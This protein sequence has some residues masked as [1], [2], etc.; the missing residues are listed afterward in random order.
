MFCVGGPMSRG[1]PSLPFG[2][3][4][5]HG[6]G[7]EGERARAGQAGRHR[8][9]DV[10]IGL[11]RLREGRGRGEEKRKDERGAHGQKAYAPHP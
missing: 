4:T 5:Q 11:D 10:V 7:Q 8:V 6:R 3:R 2:H 9:D 1:S